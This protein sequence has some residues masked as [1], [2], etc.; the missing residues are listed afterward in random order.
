MSVSLL[1]DADG[2]I[3][4][5]AAAA[6]KVIPWDDDI[7]TVH[8]DLNEARDIA[9]GKIEALREKIPGPTNVVLC[10]SCSSRKYFRHTLYPAYKGHRGKAMRPPLVRRDLTAWAK[11]QY[12]YY[13]RPGLEADDVI[14]ILATSKVIVSGPKTIVSPDKDLLQIPGNHLTKTGSTVYRQPE[15]AERQ[16]WLQVLTG[17]ATDGY[18]GC[19]GIGAVRAERM[20]EEADPSEYPKIA[21]DAYVKAGAADTFE[22]M[23]NVARILTA[24]TYNFKTKEPILWQKPS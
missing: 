14:G 1:I 21:F 23:V 10:F 4:A 16:L 2:I 3:F 5:A 15:E 19:P 6:E 17:D 22:T 18:P 24:D 9:Y 20:L 11:G 13:E 7:H 8:A 12:E